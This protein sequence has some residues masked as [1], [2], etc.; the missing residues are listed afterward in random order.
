MRYWLLV[1]HEDD[2]AEQQAYEVDS[3]EPLGGVP[4]E[5]ADG[6]EVALAGPGGVFALGAVEDGRVA[7]RRRLEE[8]SEVEG[9]A[10]DAPEGWRPLD[11]AAW[12]SLIGSL[13]TAER[14]SDRSGAR[15]VGP[16][17]A[18]PR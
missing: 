1:L 11:P 15:R 5:A 9:A 13:P 7:Y 8:P 16:D 6:D 17:R 3:V 18:A 2:F 12:E 14:R 4:A 10:E